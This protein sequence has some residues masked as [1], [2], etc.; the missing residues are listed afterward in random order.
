[1]ASITAC[2]WSRLGI[3][4]S[5]WP[6]SRVVRQIGNTWVIRDTSGW[7][8]VIGTRDSG[9]YKHQAVWIKLQQRLDSS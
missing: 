5:D 8:E 7:V 9:K 4:S 2:Y 6:I 3:L 1:M